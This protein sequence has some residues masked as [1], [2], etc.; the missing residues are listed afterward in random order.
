MLAVCSA[1]EADRREKWASIYDS[2]WRIRQ[3]AGGVSRDGAREVDVGMGAAQRA[4]QGAVSKIVGNLV[5][6]R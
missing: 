4:E 6:T 5:G 3:G 2:K 1:I